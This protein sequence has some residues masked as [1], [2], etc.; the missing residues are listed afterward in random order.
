MGPTRSK[1]APARR[2]DYEAGV[3]TVPLRVVQALHA[4]GRSK[5]AQ[6]DWAAILL[7]KVV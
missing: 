4:V 6:A 3:P 2:T 1:H 5:S 7:V